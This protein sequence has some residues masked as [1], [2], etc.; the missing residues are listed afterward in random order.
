MKNLLAIF[1][2][3]IMVPGCALMPSRFTATTSF[4]DRFHQTGYTTGFQ[5]DLKPRKV[6][7]EEYVT[8]DGGTAEMDAL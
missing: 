5:W 3:I 8:K 6:I 7:R 4:D 1:L 2:S